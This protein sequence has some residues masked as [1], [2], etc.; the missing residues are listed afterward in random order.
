MLHVCSQ[1]AAQMQLSNEAEDMEG[2]HHTTRD[3]IT[4]TP[5]C[6]PFLRKPPT[7][8]VPVCINLR[9]P[10][11]HSATVLQ[12]LSPSLLTFSGCPYTGDRLL[13]HFGSSTSSTT[14][15]VLCW[16]LFARSGSF[17]RCTRCVEMPC[18]QAPPPPRVPGGASSPTHGVVCHCVPPICTPTM[19]GFPTLF[20]R[21]PPHHG[22]QG[23]LPSSLTHGV[24]CHCV[25]SALEAATK[26]SQACTT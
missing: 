10:R 7:R 13:A 14:H 4:G 8:P 23:C 19:V 26:A 22:S 16:S 15:L 11:C 24:T 5:R 12:P 9:H 21:H 20:R 25:R 1:V 6:L 3:P 18:S 17:R 2:V